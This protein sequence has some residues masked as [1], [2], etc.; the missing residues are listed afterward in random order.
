MSCTI[1]KN[2]QVVVIVGNHPKPGFF[3]AVAQAFKA[4]QRATVRWIDSW[5]SRQGDAVRAG[6]DDR[7]EADRET[8]ERLKALGYLN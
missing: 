8:L 6:D 5:G 1:Q 2:L 4:V 3:I 7:S